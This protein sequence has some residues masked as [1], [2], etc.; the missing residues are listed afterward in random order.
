MV[1]TNKVKARIVELGMT[2]TDVADFMKMAQPTLSQKINNIR[3]MDL[4][5]ALRLATRLKIPVSDYEDYFFYN[6][7]AQRNIDESDLAYEDE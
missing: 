3:P 5:E 4:D 7:V 6:P 1:N 2:Q